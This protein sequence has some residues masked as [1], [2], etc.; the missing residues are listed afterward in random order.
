MHKIETHS[1]P[2]IELKK[3]CGF[4]KGRIHAIFSDNSSLIFQNNNEC[5][6]YFFANGEK[7][8]FYLENTPT[9]DDI[10]F[11]VNLVLK[12]NNEY[13][14]E[15][16]MDL[17]DLYENNEKFLRLSKLDHCTWPVKPKSIQKY[18]QIKQDD[19]IEFSSVDNVATLRLMDNGAVFEV[20]YLQLLK[21]KKPMWVNKAHY[22]NKE[23]TSSTIE[24]IKGLSS[25]K[26]SN[27]ENS[28][29]L[30]LAF[31]YIKIKKT[32]SIFNYP[33]RWAYPLFISFQRFEE[34]HAKKGFSIRF[35]PNY[36]Q[37]FLPFLESFLRE[38]LEET[39]KFN[40]DLSQIGILFATPDSVIS[41][42]PNIK[43][44]LEDNK[45]DSRVL[46]KNDIWQKDNVNP[47]ADFYLNDMK[48]HHQ[49]SQE[50]VFWLSPKE[51]TL[52]WIKSDNSLIISSN[53]A[54]FFTH[55]YKNI[56][57][58]IGDSNNDYEGFEHKFSKD[59]VALVT[60]SKKNTASYN[61]QEVVYDSVK[62]VKKS[63]LSNLEHKS[64]EALFSNEAEKID[65]YKTLPFELINKKKNDYGSFE[66][67]RNRSIKIAFTDRT[68]LRINFGEEFAN[69]LSKF[70]EQIRV[71]IDNPKE[72]EYYVNIAV[73]YFEDI[74]TDPQTKLNR[75]QET[76]YRK[77][78]IDY[79]LEKNKRLLQLM[80]NK[81]PDYTTDPEQFTY[82]TQYDA[83][84]GS[85]QM[86]WSQIESSTFDR[87]E[88]N[89]RI[90][91]QIKANEKIL[92]QIKSSF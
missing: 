78:M 56:K 19:A 1:Y 84:L 25:K 34:I 91:E 83:D 67:F 73:Q 35:Q 14:E 42:L 76:M 15:T 21:K 63:Q 2:K 5:I 72:F 46:T 92:S 3:L 85:R 51:E 38:D 79:E 11:K 54:N 32:F 26:I 86:K 4:A 29:V 27:K 13:S 65:F 71:R 37:N 49:I 12:K 31:E 8:R 41:E 77:A 87:D 36:S 50:F 18:L 44:D 69:I 75:I 39:E 66:A 88:M 58:T 81:L 68:V 45:K 23:K 60:R 74:F 62:I 17:E 7:I 55:F 48:L 61:L 9:R 33:A 82:Q 10:K 22:E 52:V 47:I 40:P 6:T 57:I 43:I 53:E 89:K 20:E 90:Q 30:K 59:T 16:F 80:T 24:L 70:G 28:N 64:E